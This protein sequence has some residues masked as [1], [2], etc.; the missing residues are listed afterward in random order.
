MPDDAFDAENFPEELYL[1]AFGD[2]RQA[3]IAGA[4]GTGF[5]HYI[6]FGR[7]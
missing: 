2:V 5:Q 4:F 1:L 7:R 3:V 6:A